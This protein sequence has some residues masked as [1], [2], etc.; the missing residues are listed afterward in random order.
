MTNV[1]DFQA[2]R[3]KKAP[4]VAAEQP[5]ADPFASPP[6]MEVK[7]FDGADGPVRLIG[8]FLNPARLRDGARRL[9]L[10]ARALLAQAYTHDPDDH[11]LPRMVVTL[12]HSGKIQCEV[13]NGHGDDGK[14]TP[15]DWRW[16]RGAL[17]HIGHALDEA[18]RGQ[19]P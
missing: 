10:L 12:Y 11:E 8:Q 18:Q 6:W 13:F 9:V 2:Y 5:A 14:F 7:M 17:P 19:T 16:A 1:L 15:D 3:Q 4:A